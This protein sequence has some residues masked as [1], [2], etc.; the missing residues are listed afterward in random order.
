MLYWSAILQDYLIK[1][2]TRSRYYDP[3]HFDKYIPFII[4]KNKMIILHILMTVE[5]K[6]IY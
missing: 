6:K 1:Y 4:L 3:F 2:L 5:I